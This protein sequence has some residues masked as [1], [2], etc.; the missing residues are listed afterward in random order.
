MKKHV[1]F[2]VVTALCLSLCSCQSPDYEA[3]ASV[4]TTGSWAKVNFVDAYNDPTDEWYLAIDV[5]G[6]CKRGTVKEEPILA[7]FTIEEG[8]LYLSVLKNCTEPIVGTQVS[9]E[10][11][12]IDCKNENDEEFSFVGTLGQGEDKMLVSGP[13]E[14]LDQF[15]KAKE[16]MFAVVFPSDL[17][18]TYYFTLNNN[19]LSENPVL[20]SAMDEMTERR[21]SWYYELGNYQLQIGNLDAAHRIFSQL[22][23]YQ[24]A[25]QKIV[26]IQDLNEK[27]LAL[28]KDTTEIFVA[29][30]NQHTVALREDG[31][32]VATGYNGEGQCNTG[33]WTDII[34]IEVGFWNTFGIKSTGEV[35]STGYNDNGQ[36]NVA[37]W[38]DIVDVE[39]SAWHTIGL[40]SDGTVAAVGDSEYYTAHE[41]TSNVSDWTNIIDI[42]VTE[43]S[44]LGL[45]EDGTIVMAGMAGYNKF[46]LEWTDIVAIDAEDDIIVGLKSDG[47]VIE[48]YGRNVFPWTDIV[49]IS[50]G[51]SHILGLKSDGTVVAHVFHRDDSGQ[52]NVLGWSDIVDISAGWGHSVGLKADG[53][54]VAIGDNSDGQC[55]ISGWKNIQL[56]N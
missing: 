21:Y 16:L 54:A 49:K 43:Y 36:S 35:V 30:G 20:A 46:V 13:F 33:S 24:D 45:K 40:K 52:G 17:D 9:E 53:T 34:A 14:N 7:T 32:V 44:C 15:T 3:L 6:V 25:A 42:A 55:N 56:P 4:R 51:Y 19:S 5:E 11:I 50:C 37:N 10:V 47:T 18:A 48:S 28:R 26:E 22:G 39:A 8:L 38:T 23:D 29:A 27:N 31:T 1:I 41:G 2:W 12:I